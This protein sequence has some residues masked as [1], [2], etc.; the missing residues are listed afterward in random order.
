MLEGEN[1]PPRV[2]GPLRSSSLPSACACVVEGGRK[3]F[4]ALAAVGESVAPPKSNTP[5]LRRLLMVRLNKPSSFLASFS[6]AASFAMLSLRRQEAFASRDARRR[7]TLSHATL[8]D[9]AQAS[10]TAPSAAHAVHV[11]FSSSCSKECPSVIGGAIS[12]PLRHSICLS[13]LRSRWSGKGREGDRRSWG[14]QADSLRR[15]AFLAAAV[16]LQAL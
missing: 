2:D 3:Q 4:A 15:S 16:T 12:L 7:R 11:C 8:A 14:I 13:T 9:R 5:A 1:K 10:T 6:H